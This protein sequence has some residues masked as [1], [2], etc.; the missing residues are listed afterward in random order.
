VLQFGK[1]D[2]YLGA[3]R[4]LACMPGLPLFGHG[5]WEGLSEHYGMDIAHPTQAEETDPD[6]VA[7][8]DRHIR[9]LLR[10]RPRFSS[11]EHFYLFDFLKEK[12]VDENVIVFS[13]C[14]GEHTALVLF[15]NCA[16]PT[17]GRLHHTVRQMCSLQDSAIRSQSLCQA[18][19]CPHDGAVRLKLR[20]FTQ[21]R[22]MTF[23]LDEIRGQ[24]LT[25][26]LGPY[27]SHVFDVTWG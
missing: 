19:R 5:Q 24:G 21:G 17:R 12:D 23:N 11:A 16:A 4:L 27:E 2:K 9:P 14:V 7:L 22:S 18:L 20:D 10:Q 6:L 25:F 15:N 1:Q 26:E 13:T 8:H 3:C